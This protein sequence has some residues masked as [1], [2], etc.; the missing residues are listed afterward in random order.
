MRSLQREA[1]MS[2]PVSSSHSPVKMQRYLAISLFFAMAGS[3]PFTPS[4][5]VLQPFTRA[6]FMVVAYSVLVLAARS[7]RRS[8]TAPWRIFPVPLAAYLLWS[9]CSIGWSL[10]PA[11]S[12]IRIAEAVLTFLYLQSFIFTIGQ[13]CKSIAGIAQIIAVAFLGVSAFGLAVNVALFH[14]PLYFWV[15]PDVPERPRFTFGYLHP[16]AAGD[17]LALG[18]LGAAFAPWRLVAKLCAAAFLF[19]LLTLSDSTAARFCVLA[20]LPMAYIVGGQNAWHQSWRAASIAGA[21]AIGAAVLVALGKGQLADLTSPDNARLFTLT[22]RVEIWKIILNNGLATT[23]FGYGFEAARYAITPLVGRSYHAH[24]LYLNVLVETGIIGFVIFLFIILQWFR[25]L[26][27]HGEIFAWT[28]MAYVLAL[29][30][31]NPGMFTKQ[32]IM[33]AFLLSYHLPA[34][35]PRLL[36]KPSRQSYFAQNVPV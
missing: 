16:L 26:L 13:S 28:L 5:G 22:G 33:F 25:R 35:Y 34:L 18:V 19:F 9:M 21:M 11:N 7:D 32:T 23:P 6:A 17:I 10:N 24:N 4:E 20:L 15:N 12:A 14:T 8:V 31:N 30:M 36:P 27:N 1:Q 29:S 3:I 2:S